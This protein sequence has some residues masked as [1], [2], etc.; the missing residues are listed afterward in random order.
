MFNV[1]GCSMID[2]V[3]KYNYVVVTCDEVKSCDNQC[4]AP[5]H[6]YV[7]Q[8]WARAPSLLTLEHVDLKGAESASVD[9]LTKVVIK[10]V[11]SVGAMTRMI[12][13]IC[14]HVLVVMVQ[15]RSLETRTS[16]QTRIRNKFALH[17]LLFCTKLTMSC[18]PCLTCPLS[19]ALRMYFNFFIT[20]LASH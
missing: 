16:A 3:N 18:N 15:A 4:W 14:S 12:L 6:I 20:T 10:V 13:G 9:S 7:V 1:I 5:I 19:N 17:L 8:I 11:T 2:V